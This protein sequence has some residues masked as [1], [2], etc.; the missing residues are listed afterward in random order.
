MKVTEHN[1]ERRQFTHIRAKEHLYERIKNGHWPVNSIIPSEN[2]LAE[3]YKVSRSTIRKALKML[4]DEGVLRAEQGRG[5]IVTAKI[6][7]RDSRAAK[8]IG[9]VLSKIDT[10]FDFLQYGSIAG[11][12]NVIEE[13][14]Y[15]LNIYVLSRNSSDEVMASQLNE[16]SRK[17]VSGLMI[18]CQQVL[19][20]DIVE[21]NKYI[22]TVSFLHDCAYAAVPS[23]YIDWRRAT[24]KASMHLAKQG[25][26]DQVVLLPYGTFWAMT[27]QNI[28]KGMRYSQEE[29]DLTF[30]K[31]N[32]IYAFHDQ[33]V[34]SYKKSIEPVLARI[35]KGSRVA[36]ITYYNWPAIEIVKYALANQVK[37]PQEVAVVA[38]VD[39]SFLDN[40]PIPVTAV[41]CNR[42]EL[43]NRAITRLLDM[44][45]EKCDN[46]GDLD[47]PV[48][49]ELI[50]RESSSKAGSDK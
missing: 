6:V 25:F 30:D 31:D 41:D 22:P 23:Y 39:S 50:V 21:F 34:D 43:A 11:I 45:E 10:E 13:Y 48:Y 32:I 18:S 20:T 19:N 35:K 28:I 14:G 9:V 15:H 37:I 17:D 26:K 36:F 44:L 5:R 4:E 1:R 47:N 16:I 38:L 42:K 29:N 27:Q 33:E 40:S 2:K 24:Y 49:G 46:T 12:Q 3:Q 8:T 7:K